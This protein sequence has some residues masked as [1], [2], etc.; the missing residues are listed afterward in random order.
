MKN[1]STFVLKAVIFLIAAAVLVMCAFILFLI[2]QGAGDYL[3]VLIGMLIAAIPFFMGLYQAF[4]LLTNIDKDNAFSENSVTALKHIKYCAGIISVV[5]ILLSPFIFIA[6]EKDDAPGAIV[7][8]LVI[9]F[10]SLVVSVF[11]AVLQKL[12]QNGMEIKS[13]NDLTV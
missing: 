9:I 2:G 10:A 7:I 5:Y 1:G 11:A 13:E 12:L 8:G 3:P 4:R 6:A